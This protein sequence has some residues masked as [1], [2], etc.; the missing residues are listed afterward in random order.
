MVYNT[1]YF[2]F[3]TYLKKTNTLWS[4]LGKWGLHPRLLSKN[5]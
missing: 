2:I 3:I 5:G 4:V 1:N